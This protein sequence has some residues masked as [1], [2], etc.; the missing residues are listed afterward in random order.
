LRNL[1][2]ALLIIIVTTA[3]LHFPYDVDAPLT[4]QELETARNYYAEAYRKPVT[5]DDGTCLPR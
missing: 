3:A 5:K 2:L 1:A 4:Q